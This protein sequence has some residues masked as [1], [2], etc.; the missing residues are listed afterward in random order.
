M[1]SWQWNFFIVDIFFSFLQAALKP[2]NQEY[3]FESTIINDLLAKV[4]GDANEK[5][6]KLAEAQKLDK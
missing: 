4:K 5:V 3:K 6:S 2:I 1:F